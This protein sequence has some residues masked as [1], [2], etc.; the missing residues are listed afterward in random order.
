LLEDGE[1]IM[2]KLQD[3]EKQVGKAIDNFKTELE[4]IDVDVEKWSFTVAKTEK[5]ITLEGAV[6]V[7]I[8]K[9]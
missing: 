2:E 5:G 1:C 6:K 8:A 4:K 9:K 3:I 7:N